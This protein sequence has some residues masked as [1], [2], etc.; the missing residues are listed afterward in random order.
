MNKRIQELIEQS[1]EYA[2]NLGLS[3]DEWCDV[4]MEKLAE[5]I[6]LECSNIA[7]S[8]EQHEGPGDCATAEYMK[9]RFGVEE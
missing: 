7:N 6:V 9:E 3:G 4:Q 2:N 5:L 1:Y 8:L